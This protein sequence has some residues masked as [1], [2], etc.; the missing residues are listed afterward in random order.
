LPP[1]DSLGLLVALGAQLRGLAREALPHAV[2]HRLGDLFGQVD[3]LHAHVHERDAELPHG[4]ARELQ[5]VANELGTLGGHDLLDR[6]LGDDALQAVLDDLGQAPGGRFLVAG[7]REVELADVGHAPLHE[8]VDVQDLALAREEGLGRVVP[9]QHAAVE[10]LHRLDPRDLEV[11]ARLEVRR[12]DL[13]QP[14]LDGE[15]GL[16][17]GEHRGGHEPRHE[18]DADQYL[19]CAAIH[20]SA[21]SGHADPRPRSRCHPRA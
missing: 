19:E 16:P 6:A 9:R 20:F 4:S 18:Q 2:I 14:E 21:P 8:E 15:L 5:D 1:A 3:A 13:A 17:D 11:Q 7:G 10:L 12:D